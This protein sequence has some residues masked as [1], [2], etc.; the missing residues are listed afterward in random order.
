MNKEI[1]TVLINCSTFHNWV[2]PKGKISIDSILISFPYGL[3][4]EGV[5]LLLYEWALSTE[6]VSLSP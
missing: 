3:S 1:Q 5:V 4:T 6:S 2:E